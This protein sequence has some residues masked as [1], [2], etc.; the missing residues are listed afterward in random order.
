MYFNEFG[1][2]T[3]QLCT[4]LLPGCI[5]EVH[6]PAGECPFFHH[7][8]MAAIPALLHGLEEAQNTICRKLGQGAV[9]MDL[10]PAGVAP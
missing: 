8:V 7:K 3:L 2:Q 1:K 6:P 10:G 9:N 5:L 4:S